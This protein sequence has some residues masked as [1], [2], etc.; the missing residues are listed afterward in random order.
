MFSSRAPVQPLNFAPKAQ[1][2]PGL[3]ATSTRPPLF[4]RPDPRRILCRPVEALAF[5]GN[6]GEGGSWGSHSR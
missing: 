1:P 4:G 3:Q 5:R 6:G 2:V